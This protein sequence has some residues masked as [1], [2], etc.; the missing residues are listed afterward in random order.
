MVANLPS[1]SPDGTRVA[2]FYWDERASPM[3]GVVIFPLA[4]RQPTKRLNIVPDAV[5]GFALHWSPDGRAI[6]HLDENLSNLWSEPVDGGPPT[7]VTNFNG[8]QIFNFAWSHDGKWL[9]LARGKVT[10]DVV[11]ITDLK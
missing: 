5:N 4:G 11:L 9:A 3:Q 1:I 8:D 2:S 10:N 7:Q 6:L